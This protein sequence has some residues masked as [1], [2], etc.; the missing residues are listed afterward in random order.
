MSTTYK[1]R[2]IQV[3]PPCVFI[4]LLYTLAWNSK[5]MYACLAC[6]MAAVTAS[7]K[8]NNHCKFKIRTKPPLKHENIVLP[9]SL[10]THLNKSI[11]YDQWRCPVLLFIMADTTSQPK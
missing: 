10:R 11:R 4:I 3:C 9:L 2:F 5:E 6:S 7:N 8:A 1:F